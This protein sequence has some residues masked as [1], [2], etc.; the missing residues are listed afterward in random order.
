MKSRTGSRLM[1]GP[2]ST[3]LQLSRGRSRARST[4]WRRKSSHGTVMMRRAGGGH[5]P[6]HRSDYNFVYSDR[7]A[8]CLSVPI[9]PATRRLAWAHTSCEQLGRQGAA[10]RKN[11]AGRWLSSPAPS[12]RS[13]GDPADDAQEPS[14][15]TLDGGP[16][17]AQA[18]D[19]RT[20]AYVA[21]VASWRTA[22]LLDGADSRRSRWSHSYASAK[23]VHH[24]TSE[25][26]D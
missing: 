12:R 25:G 17:R 23:L 8:R 26:T 20:P 10:R 1:H 18:H 2:R 13:D 9:R 19:D 5:D 16:A 21:G 14:A 15:P 22:C 7:S 24:I 11:Q 6:G 4:G 3:V